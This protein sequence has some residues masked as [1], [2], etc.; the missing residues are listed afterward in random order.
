MY[1]VVPTRETNCKK[2]KA[3]KKLI[4]FSSINGDHSQITQAITSETN[5]NLLN[6]QEQ[7]KNKKQKKN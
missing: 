3:K 6:K 1:G 2:G 7:N 4:F 5:D